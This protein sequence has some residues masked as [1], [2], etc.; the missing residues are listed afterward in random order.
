M[1]I[2]EKY[3]QAVREDLSVKGRENVVRELE[4]LL[5][6]EIEEKF[7]PSPTEEE[8][9][10]FLKEFGSPSKVADMYRGKT[11]ILAPEY[12]QLYFLV[13]RI[14]ALAMTIAFT[15]IFFIKLFA[16]QIEDGKVWNEI[17]QTINSIFTTSI[18]GI[19]MFTLVMIIISKAKK[20]IPEEEWNPKTLKKKKVEKN[21]GSHSIVEIIISLIG[22][23]AVVVIANFFPELFTKAENLFLTSGLSLGHRVAVDVFVTYL[24]VLNV[25][26]VTQLVLELLHL[27]FRTPTRNILVYE[28]LIKTFSFI[29]SLVMFLDKSLFYD[30]TGMI[31][32]RAIFLLATIG[33][34]IAVL[35]MLGKIIKR[36][37]EV[38]A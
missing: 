5:L 8:I 31:G 12:T 38:L 10:D 19:G 15:V 34:G 18:S 32:F 27:K 25:S 17:L 35:E 2:I 24:I 28:L 33:G 26:W 20:E 14:I 4:S 21:D 36:K 22:L 23:P 6:D 30:Y 7:G 13:I 16:G 9:S 3:L 1:K 11:V 29:I 37:Y